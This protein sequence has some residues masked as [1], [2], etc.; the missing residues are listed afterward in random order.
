MTSEFEA[1]AA[2]LKNTLIRVA[3]RRA[4]LGKPKKAERSV[5]QDLVNTSGISIAPPGHKSSGVGSVPGG[6]PVHVD[7]K[8]FTSLRNL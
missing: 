6:Y 2:E 4:N 8:G 5:S 1:M 7:I 3:E